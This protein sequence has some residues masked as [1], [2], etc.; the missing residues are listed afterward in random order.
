M[1]HF[2]KAVSKEKKWKEFPKK[3]D[4]VH[5]QKCPVDKVQICSKI[6]TLQCDKNVGRGKLGR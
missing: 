2:A 6:I 1:F 4:I 3:I 5:Q